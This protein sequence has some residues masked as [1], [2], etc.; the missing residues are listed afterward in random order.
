MG[1]PGINERKFNQNAP[2]ENDLNYALRVLVVMYRNYNGNSNTLHEK[3]TLK[4]ITL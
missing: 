4:R 1:F 2:S 3:R